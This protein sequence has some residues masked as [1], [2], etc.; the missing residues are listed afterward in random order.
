MN[1]FLAEFG[2]RLAAV[3]SRRGARIEPPGLD[4]EAARELLELARVTAHTKERRFAPLACFVAGIAVER[5][6]RA[7]PGTSEAS[8]AGYVREVRE[9]I[10]QNR[11]A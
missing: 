5:I 10:E 11:S 7:A 9:E 3:A 2:Q 4:D 1:E 6:R 8:I